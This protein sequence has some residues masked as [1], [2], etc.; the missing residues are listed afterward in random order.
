MFHLKIDPRTNTVS[1][2][3]TTEGPLRH[4]F[5]R[6]WESE[7]LLGL[8]EEGRQTGALAAESL[9]ARIASLGQL[10]PLNR[11]QIQRLLA[12]LEEFFARLPELK[13]SIA[14]PPRKRTVGPWSLVHL[15]VLTWEVEGHSAPMQWPYPT[16]IQSNNIDTLHAF[17]SQLMVA[18]ALAVEGQFDSALHSLRGFETTLLSEEGQCLLH[19]RLGHWHHHSGDHKAARACAEAVLA[20]PVARDPGLSGHAQFFLRRIEYDEN[21]GQNWVALWES[22]A[23]PPATGNAKTTDCRTLS[24][25]HNLRALLARRR[26]HQVSKAVTVAAPGEGA[27]ALH[28]LAL[29]HLQAAIYGA[30]WARDWSSVQAYVANLAFH[31]QSCLPLPAPVG[32][33]HDQV[34]EWHRLTLAYEDKLGAGRDS[35]WEYI[36]FAMFWLDHRDRLSPSAV[37]DPISHHIG[38]TAPDQPAFYE[39]ALQRLRECG[40]DR[41][42]AIGHSLYLQFAQE[43]MAGGARERVLHEQVVQLSDLLSRQTDAHLRQSLAAEGYTRHWPQALRRL[44]ERRGAAGSRQPGRDC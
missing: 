11:T 42:V 18:D 33:C 17:L 20:R 30:L 10:K 5:L 32:V 22:T 36:F 40:D 8:L 29:L 9:Q 7:F 23:V 14:T 1:I 31:L 25:W 37:P 4:E 34:L 35:A 28:Q 43:H 15:G 19:M 39:R 44:L 16:L 6:R 41:Q 38:G 3:S 26:M 2:E 24:E 21:P 13:A 12:G 27:D